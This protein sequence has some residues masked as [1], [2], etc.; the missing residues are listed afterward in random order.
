MFG[1]AGSS[2]FAPE[3]MYGYLTPGVE[4]G[5]LPP[6]SVTWDPQA[7]P[8]EVFAA[9]DIFCLI[10]TDPKDYGLPRM[11]VGPKSDGLVRVENAY[12]RRAHRAY[13]YKSHSG[14]YGE[15][16]SEEG[17]QN[18]RRFL[19]G[20]WQVRV[21]LVGLPDAEDEPVWQA[22]MR[23]SIRGLSI[24]MSEQMAAHW[25]PIQLNEEI[26]RGRDTTG[27]AVTLVGTF[28]LEPHRA[29]P[30]QPL[31]P[32]GNMSAHD[33]RMRYTLTLRVFKLNERHGGFAFSDHLEQVPDWQD[34]LIVDLGPGAD[35]G[36]LQAWAAWNSM[37]G[38]SYD[39]FDPIT[40]GLPAGQREPVTFQR[41]G[42]HYI[43]EVGL[44][45]EARALPVLGGEARLRISVCDRQTTR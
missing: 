37:V 8:E 39:S 6:R 30:G 17:Y 41:A 3:K 36:G 13:V 44:P 20:R 19:F 29:A 45:S 11:A 15:V 5:A 14:R 35:G 9:D 18:L 24:V 43:G 33:R 1:P 40:E 2:I 22:D 27:R 21:D 28:L 25:C 38:G 4:F 12:V 31:P 16:N 7:V 42:D 10:G 26:R 23:L 34:W 32:P